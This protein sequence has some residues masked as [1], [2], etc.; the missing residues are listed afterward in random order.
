MVVGPQ[1]P[2]IA[3]PPQRGHKNGLCQA[4]PTGPNRSQRVPNLPDRPTGAAHR[5]PAGSP[6][7][8]HTCR[9]APKGPQ[10]RLL[11]GSHTG[12]QR[13]PNLPNRPIGAAQA[14]SGRQSHRVPTGPKPAKLSHR[15]RR[16]GLG[17][18][19]TTGPGGCHPREP[20]LCLHSL[21]ALSAV[22]HWPGP[23]NAL[24]PGWPFDTNRRRASRVRR[25]PHG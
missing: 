11:A 21:A 2:K 18:A 10:M 3:E 22:R 12:P 19:V 1:G 15:G 20:T 23:T 17:Q 16:Q 6:S 4:V 14:T 7:G 5:H 8:S 13:A 24:E 9:A 25:H